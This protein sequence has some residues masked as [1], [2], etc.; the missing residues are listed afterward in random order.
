[1]L[2][3]Y[4]YCILLNVLLI[5]F[6]SSIAQLVNYIYF[7]FP[8]NNYFPTD[9]AVPIIILVLLLIGTY[10]QWGKASVIAQMAHEL[11]YYFLVVCTLIYATNAVQYTPFTPIDE[12]IIAAENAWK[13]YIEKIVTWTLGHPYLIIFLTHTYDSIAYQM[14]VLPMIVISLQ[15]FS[16]LREYLCLLL[17]TT[18]MGFLLYYFFPTVAPATAIKSAV[19][20]LQQQATG[21]KFIQIHQHIP[22]STLD[23][24][25]I[26][27]PSFHTIWAWLCLYLARCRNWLFYPLLPINLILIVSCVLLGWHY[28]LDILGSFIVITVAHYIKYLTSTKITKL[29]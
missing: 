22:P 21:I 13:I 8:G 16:Y 17:L 9:T 14:A 4:N 6:L 23:G 2:R 29:A 1:M 15:Q 3:F 25:M 11:I 24:G 10:L 5:S 20:S 28:L 12:K 26:A 7:Q 27:F 18:L 19:F